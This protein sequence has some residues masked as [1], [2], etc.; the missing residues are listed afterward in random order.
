MLWLLLACGGTKEWAPPA[1]LGQL[2]ADTVRLADSPALA[3]LAPALPG[4]DALTPADLLRTPPAPTAAPDPSALLSATAADN[5]AREGV[6]L[7]VLSY[8]VA[9][10]DVKLYGFIPYKKTPFLDERRDELPGLIYA[11]GYDVLGLQEVWTDEDLQRFVREA[12]A[13]GYRAFHGPR[14]EYNDGVLIL[15]RRELI[16]GEP[17]V[18]AEHY[19][20]SDPL[21][22]SPGPHLRRGFVEVRFDHPA[23]GPLR[24]YNT[25]LL[26]WPSNWMFRMAQARQLGARVAAQGQDGSV[27]IVFGDMNAGSYYALD[28]WLNPKGE[29]ETGWWANGISYAFLQHYGQMRDLY[30][31]GAG[32]DASALDVTLSQT[33][34]ART[35]DG[36]RFDIAANC[37]LLGYPEHLTASDCN[38]LYGM[39]YKDTENPARMDQIFAYDPERRV[40]VSAADTAFTTRRSFDGSPSMEPSDHLGVALDLVIAPREAPAA[41][42][43]P[44]EAP[45]QVA[46]PA[47]PVPAKQ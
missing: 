25:H 20:E 24:V 13:A 34:A 8:N 2:S 3:H 10:L 46:P 22:Y 26:A 30:V 45:T 27:A 6:A 9:L 32:P 28:T 33:M 12:E 18:H 19:L 21:E 17:T 4:G 37:E 14:E 5:P 29:I 38:V 31:Q 35:P 7:K 11:Q 43:A 16:Q 44:S 39:Q 23:L 1:D 15:I 42:P 40:H 41:A 47:D 36:G